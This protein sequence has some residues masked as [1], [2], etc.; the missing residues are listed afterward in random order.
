MIR[1]RWIA[2]VAAVMAI[3]ALSVVAAQDEG[4][5][6]TEVIEFNGED[7]DVIVYVPSEEPGLPVMFYLHGWGGEGSEIVGELDLISVATREDFIVVAPNAREPQRL[8][9]QQDTNLMHVI[10]DMLVE[11]FAIDESRVYVIGFSGGAFMTHHLGAVMA[12]R[13]A[14]IASTE[15]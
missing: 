9:E 1:A 2:F 12:D 3:A 10:L 15:G 13:V 8:W 11:D 6:F 5:L 7:R 14:A 4:D